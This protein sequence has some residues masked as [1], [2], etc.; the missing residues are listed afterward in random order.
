MVL[1]SEVRQD[2]VTGVW[3]NRLATLWSTSSAQHSAASDIANRKNMALLTHLRWIA[4][5]GQVVT[6]AAV[7]LIFH[8]ALPLREMALVLLA[9]IELNIMTLVWLHGRVS[10]SHRTLLA[11]L[12][13]DVA[14][15]TA[16]LWLSGGASNPFISLYLLQVSLAAILLEGLSIWV[17]VASA[18]GG[19]LLLTITYLPLALPS[20]PTGEAFSLRIYGMLVCLLLNAILLVVFVTRTSRNLRERDAGLA[21]LHQHATE[22][23]HIVRMGLLATGA[24]HELGTPLS[25]LSVIVGDWKHSPP[26]VGGAEMMQDLEEMQTAIVRCKAIVSGIL[27]SAG[28]AR[29]ERSQV[30]TLRRFVDDIVAEWKAGRS[31]AITL[32]MAVTNDR[33]IV[34]DTVVKQA[35]FNLLDNAREVSPHAVHLL[36]RDE[37]DM[38]SLVVTDAG[39]GFAPQILD[40]I[41]RPYQST[42]G[43]PSRGLGLFL[44]FSVA[45]QL[46]GLVAACNLAGG[47]ARV[48]MTLPLAALA[49]AGRRDG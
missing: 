30:T 31:D 6:I 26:A 4:V 29:G 32:D 24:A 21:A 41:G 44:A 27:L 19:V 49:I 48:T 39:P 11:A 17:V 28:E 47:G 20:G 35:I 5:A 16:Q 7:E 13:F 22:E 33:P 38:L 36:V 1:K 15:L 37:K 14:A 42:K 25:L 18:C 2:S 34:F 8:T 3:L 46:G 9:L 43:A 40:Q 12:L 45:R 10:V 23:N